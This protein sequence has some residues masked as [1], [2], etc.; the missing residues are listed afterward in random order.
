MVKIGTAR[1]TGLLKG[2]YGKTGTTN[3]SRD[4]W[5]A[6]V[7][8]KYVIVVWIGRDDY[9]K[10]GEKDTGGSLAAPLVARIQKSLIT[11]ME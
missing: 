8:D 3:D 2:T 5:F 9:K 6:S 11:P 10:M 4:V 7:Y 1:G